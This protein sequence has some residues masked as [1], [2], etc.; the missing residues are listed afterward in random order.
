MT[1][2]Q[3]QQARDLLKAADSYRGMSYVSRLIEIRP[4]PRLQAFLDGTG[5]LEDAEVQ[6]VLTSAR[7]LE[8]T[9]RREPR[10]K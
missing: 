2:E 4:T 1:P 10:R 7:F 3:I 5:T 9:G 6:R 8:H